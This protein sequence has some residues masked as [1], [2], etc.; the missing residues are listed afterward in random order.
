MDL[1][2]SPRKKEMQWD[3]SGVQRQK[4]CGAFCGF[5]NNVPRPGLCRARRRRA[6]PGLAGLSRAAENAATA[7]KE[8]C[9]KLGLG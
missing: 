8:A 6:A 5:P 7:R 3:D 1:F 2:P 4:H 9:I